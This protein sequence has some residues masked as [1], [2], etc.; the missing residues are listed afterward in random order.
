M[1]DL[2]EFLS[3]IRNMPGH[4]NR[5]SVMFQKIQD[6]INQIGSGVGID[7]TGHMPAPPAPQ[8]I[9]VA[10]GTDHVHV[11]ITDNS[12]RTRALNY[13]AEWSVN[14]PA[15]ANANVEDLGAARGRI[16][17]LPAKDGS[18]TPINYY[19][20]AYSSYRGSKTVSP[21]IV[22]GGDLTPTAVQLTGASQLTPLPSTGAGTAS[23]NGSQA[24]QGFG[25]PQV[26]NPSPARQLIQ[27]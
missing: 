22:H 16:L 7:A 6:A 9:N 15:F 18:G 23:T 4:W 11:T 21:R 10:A 2:G 20:R 25:T 12:A 27:I 13:F 14:D 17:S 3:E 24:G 19:F 5:I 8:K 1:L 26:V